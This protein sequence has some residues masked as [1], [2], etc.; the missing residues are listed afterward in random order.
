MNPTL[1]EDSYLLT[2]GNL[3][4]PV[5]LSKYVVEVTALTEHW[6]NFLYFATAS[7]L[8][9]REIGGLTGVQYVDPTSSRTPRSPVRTS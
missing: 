3:A 1:V 7:V 6:G 8:P 4:P 2:Y 5:A 9:A